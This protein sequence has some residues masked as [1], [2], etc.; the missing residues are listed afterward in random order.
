MNSP[1]QK[2]AEFLILSDGVFEVAQDYGAYSASSQILFNRFAQ[3]S[4]DALVVLT[5][6]CFQIEPSPFFHFGTNLDRRHG[7]S[8][9]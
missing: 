8:L 5:S 1:G 4:R 2:A 7:S 3:D 9:G 6:Q